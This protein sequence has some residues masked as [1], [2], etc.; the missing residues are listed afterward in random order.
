MYLTSHEYDTFLLHSIFISFIAFY[1][2]I[3][4]IIKLLMLPTGIVIFVTIKGLKTKVAIHT[5]LEAWIITSM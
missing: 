4:I 2:S 3:L 5:Y 1:I